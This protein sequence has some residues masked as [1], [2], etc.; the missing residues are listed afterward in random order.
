[1]GSDNA[2]NLAGQPIFK[3]INNKK[4]VDNAPVMATPRALF[5]KRKTAT[6]LVYGVAVLAIQ[7][8]TFLFV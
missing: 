1:M 4:F 2:K 8:E 3:H 6:L 5:A 7:L